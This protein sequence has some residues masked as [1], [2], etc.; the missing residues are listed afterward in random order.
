LRVSLI[1]IFAALKH[2]MVSRSRTLEYHPHVHM[3]VPGGWVNRNRHQWHKL[4][5]NYL[6][7]SRKLAAVFRGKLLGAIKPV[8]LIQP[9]APKHWVAIASKWVTA[10][11]R[12]S[13]YLDTYTAVSSIINA[14]SAKMGHRLLLSIRMGKRSYQNPLFSGRGL[15]QAGTTAYF[16]KGI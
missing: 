7:K 3:I 4:K 8:G 16:A 2:D 9:K 14:S 1:V 10:C 5:G 15:Y 6:F 12:F 13:T 11:L